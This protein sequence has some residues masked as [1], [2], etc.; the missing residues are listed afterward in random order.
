VVGCERYD[1]FNSSCAST[2]D[3][4][5]AHFLHTKLSKRD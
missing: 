3:A 4:V 1:A 2:L 5:V